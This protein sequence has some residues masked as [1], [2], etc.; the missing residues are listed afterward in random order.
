MLPC[1]LSQLKPLRPSRRI[2]RTYDK[3]VFLTHQILLLRFTVVPLP[4][5]E[6]L[7]ISKGCACVP[8][9]LL[10]IHGD[11]TALPLLSRI[12]GVVVA[13]AERV[14]GKGGIRP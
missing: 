5:I 11:V 13:G 2:R 4:L 1:P 7:L 14:P 10:S 3:P 6:I 8:L 9:Q 12:G